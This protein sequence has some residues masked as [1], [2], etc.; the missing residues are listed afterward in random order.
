MC[1][2]DF[3]ASTYHTLICR[4]CGHEKMGHLCN[5]VSYTEAQPLFVGY[6]RKARFRLI[7]LSLFHPRYSKICRETSDH[8]GTCKPKTME[9]LVKCMQNT[10]SKAKNYNSLH[11]YASI[12]LENYTCEIIPS[13]CDIEGILCDFT[14]IER[15][16]VKCYPKNRFFSYRWLLGKLL[17]KNGFG[18]FIK[19]VKPLKN[20]KSIQ[21]YEDMYSK[22]MNLYNDAGGRDTVLEN[23]QSIAGPQDDV[24]GRS[25]PESCILNCPT[26][27]HP[28]CIGG[29]MSLPG[30]G[31]HDTTGQSGDQMERVRTS[32]FEMFQLVI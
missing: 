13:K 11:L 29:G 32:F 19:Y 17:Q 30:S 31:Y 18:Q 1:D 12:H 8:I 6:S 10:K 24:S 15:S 27:S 26:R 21:K 23:V 9:E 16:H 5:V 22:I 14:N 7:L 28:S 25:S 20:K 3:F 2:H 4:E